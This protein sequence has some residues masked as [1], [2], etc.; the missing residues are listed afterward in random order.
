MTN[1]FIQIGSTVTVGAGGAANIDFSLIPSTYTDLVLKLSL[2]GSDANNYVNSRISFNGST[3]GY[4][5]K[6]LYGLGTGSGASLNN[7]VTNAVDFSSYGTGALATSNTFGSV[8]VYIPNYAGSQNKSLS[9]D[10]VSENNATAAIAA[11]TAGL[12]SNSAA[13]NQIT[14]TPSVGSF[15]QY[16]TATLYGISKS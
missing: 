16:S 10:Q 4:T 2:R 1:T 15:V 9:V 12:W 11:L 13:I 5:C 7:S 6:M 14:I 3:S 8:D